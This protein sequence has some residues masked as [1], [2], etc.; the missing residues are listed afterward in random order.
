LMIVP[1]IDPGCGKCVRR[2]GCPVS[3]MAKQAAKPV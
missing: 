3:S 1:V 2:A